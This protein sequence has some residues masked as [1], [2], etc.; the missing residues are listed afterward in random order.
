MNS[1]KYLRGK[2]MPIL[3]KLFQKIENK[4]IIFN[5]FEARISKWD[6]DFTEKENYRPIP[7]VNINGKIFKKKY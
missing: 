7:L 6:K 3:H 4:G 2:I 5:F 1:T